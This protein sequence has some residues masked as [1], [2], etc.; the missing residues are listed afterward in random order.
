MALKLSREFKVGMYIVLAIAIL[1]WGINFLKGND[2]FASGRTYY[3]IYDNTEGLTKA[4]AVQ[5]NGFQVGMIDEIYFHPDRSGRLIVK[6]K[7]QQN[8]P[9][10]AN[11]IARIHSSG[12]LGDK[13]ISLLLGDAD[14]LAQTGD[15][16]AS[17]IEGTLTDAVNEQVA[18]IKAKAESLLGSLDTAVTLLTGFLN[19]ETRNN[20]VESFDNVRKTFENLE[21]SSAILNAYLM[22]NQESF[23]Q[24]AA[25]LESI[26]RNVKD[27]NENISNVLSNLSTITDSLQKAN[28][29][30]TFKKVDS[31][32]LQLNTALERINSGEGSVG[33]LINDRELYNNLNE[34]SDALN[35][36][37]L[38]IKYNPNKYVNV[39]V[40]GSKRQYSDE[41]I[42]EIEKELKEREK[43]KERE[44]K[45]TEKKDK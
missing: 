27:N 33:A 22:N 25:N 32:L 10:A 3:A 44:Q 2:V 15:T 43:Q 14:E 38:D 29:A 31:A 23:N 21:N 28:I 20:F 1:Y 7:M 13:S 16:L 17:A 11:T 19:E 18:P 37:L 42:E 41:E 4:K 6:M 40:F 36:L 24:L 34:A 39:S 26:S 30:G 45:E 35:R 5:I 9:I 12:L 8:Y